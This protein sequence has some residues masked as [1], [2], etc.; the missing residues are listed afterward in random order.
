MASAPQV[1]DADIVSRLRLSG[2]WQSAAS[3]LA[4]ESV[5]TKTAAQEKLSVSDSELQAAFDDFRRSRGLEKAAETKSWLE[6]AGLKVEQVESALEADILA[7]KLAEKVIDDKQ[8]EQYYKQHPVDFDF[9][10]ISQIVVGDAGAARE[11]ALNARE[12]GEDFSALARQHSIDEQTRAGGGFVG[13]V[14]RI[15]ASGLPAS[16]ADR[17]FAASA[18]EIVG[19]FERGETHCLIRVEENGRLELDDE[20]KSVI[21]GQLFSQWLAERT[22]GNGQK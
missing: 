7:S 1:A 12:E 20:L 11:L 22:F 17:I 10:R 6:S 13:L 21:R 15:D 4:Q 19:P 3:E 8:I 14:T 9:A 2:A 16:I 18:S 5:I